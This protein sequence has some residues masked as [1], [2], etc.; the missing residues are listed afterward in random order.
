MSNASRHV[1]IIGAGI[2]GLAAARTLADAGA[3]VELI[4]SSDRIGGR[5]ASDTVG[6]FTL[7]RGFQIYLSAYPEGKQLQ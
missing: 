1:T 7:D 4:E 2:A 5:V 6:G 3:T